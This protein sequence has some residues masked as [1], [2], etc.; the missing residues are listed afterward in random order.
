MREVGGILG[1]NDRPNVAERDVD[2]LLAVPIP[3]LCIQAA[4]IVSNVPLTEQ[5][6]MAR[7]SRATRSHTLQYCDVSSITKRYNMCLQGLYKR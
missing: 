6:L 2:H 7:T 5:Y 1:V 3:F 4:Q